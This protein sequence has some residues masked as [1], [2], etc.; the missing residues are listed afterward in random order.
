[1]RFFSDELVALA[2]REYGVTTDPRQR[3]VAGHSSGGAFAFWAAY[4][5]PEAFG[6][7]IVSSQAWRPV[8]EITPTHVRARFFMSA[9]LYEARFLRTTRHT[10]SALRAEGY[11]VVFEEF[12]AGHSSDHYETML[13]DRLQRIF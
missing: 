3:V 2:V 12:A 1:M 7:G 6:N 5:H 11:E 9:G 10:A 13:I 8:D 4:Q